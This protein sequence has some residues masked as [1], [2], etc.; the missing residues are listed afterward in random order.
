M[1]RNGRLRGEIIYLYSLYG[2]KRK[3]NID[4]L[5]SD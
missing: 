5:E 3:K 2:N 1:K 4:N